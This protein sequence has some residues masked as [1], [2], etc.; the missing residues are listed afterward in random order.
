MVVLKVMEDAGKLMA[1]GWG[2]TMHLV[3]MLPTILLHL[4]FQSAV[5]GLTRFTPEVYTAW[6]KSRTDILDFSHAPPLQSDRKVIDVLC[7]EI[8]KNVH[9]TPDKVKAS[10]PTWLLSMANVSM[11]GVKAAEVGAGDG[12]TSSPHMSHSPVPCASCSPILPHMR[13]CCQK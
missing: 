6:P 4:T 1:D 9:G 8:V 13:V 2:I 5:P 10:Q 11:I 12:P 7:E 3:D